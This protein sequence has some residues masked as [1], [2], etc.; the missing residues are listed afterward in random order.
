METGLDWGAG[1]PVAMYVVETGTEYG[2]CM[3][4]IWRQLVGHVGLARHLAFDGGRL[5]LWV[6]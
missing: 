4:G 2:G 6:W 5:G 3:L 1:W